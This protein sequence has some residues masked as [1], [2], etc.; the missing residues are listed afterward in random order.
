MPYIGP[1][2]VKSVD[3]IEEKYNG[4]IEL[5]NVTYADG[6]QQALT[7]KMV[8]SCTTDESTDLTSLRDKR[9]QPVVAGILELMLEWGVALSEVNFITNSIALSVNA[10]MNAATQKFWGK[11]EQDLDLIEVDKVLKQKL[12]VQDIID[13]APEATA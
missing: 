10:S 2:E 12:T 3:P 9:V 6:T 7:K 8:D 13:P 4:T 1:K 5:V 11:A